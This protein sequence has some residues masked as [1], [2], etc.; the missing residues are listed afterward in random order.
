MERRKAS[1]EI[2]GGAWW[3]EGR[4]RVAECAASI[5][6]VRQHCAGFILGL[7]DKTERPSDCKPA[8]A[9]S[10]FLVEDYGVD[11][12][13]A[14]HARARRIHGLLGGLSGFGGT[15]SVW[16]VVNGVDARH[17]RHARAR[18]IH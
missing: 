9:D 4:T 2:D 17:A 3:R 5:P 18:R 10:A 14:R 7:V 11:A 15:G 12:R 8:N 1:A 16:V 13:H 6:V